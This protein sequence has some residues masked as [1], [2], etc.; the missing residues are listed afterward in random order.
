MVKED[1][2]GPA[3]PDGDVAAPTPTA[4]TAGGGGEEGEEGR[5]LEL[6]DEGR[7]CTEEA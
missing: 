5:G 6:R 3:V 2:A 1:G 4:V 7:E